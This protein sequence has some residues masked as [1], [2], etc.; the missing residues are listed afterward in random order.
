MEKKKPIFKRWWFWVLVVLVLLF[1]IGSGGSEEEAK[2]TA[3]VEPTMEVTPEPEPTEE[4]EPVRENPLDYIGL[5][6][7][8]MRTAYNEYDAALNDAYTNGT[9]ATASAEEA[10]EIENQ[11]AEEI[12]GKYGIS[13]DE[14]DDIYAYA[15]FGYLYDIDP[16]SLKVSFGDTED[17]TI[18]GTVMVVKAKIGSSYSNRSTITQ[19]FF[20][21]CDLICNQ[22]CGEFDEIQYWAVADMQD[23]S[24]SKV[25]SFTV[26]GDVIEVIAANDVQAFWQELDKYVDDL[27][28]LP[29]LQS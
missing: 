29:S 7:E 23:G 22:G 28:V 21:V 26:P 16:D 24:E 4:P 20:N 9:A 12:A 1:A 19:N 25:V 17:I 18:N 6:T 2:P 8:E 13:V 5:S 14:L 10:A 27:W 3:T 15:G 11:I